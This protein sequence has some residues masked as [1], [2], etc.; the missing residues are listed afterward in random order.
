MSRCEA[1]TPEQQSG[2]A[3]F[4]ALVRA[5]GGQDA[6]AVETGVRRQKISDMT[7][8]N[9][10]VYPT[11]DLIDA[12]EARTVGW[13]GWPHVT[14]WLCRQR[15]GLFVPLPVMA[16]DHA[17]LAMGVVEMAGELGDVSRAVSDALCPDGDGGRAVTAAERRRALEELDALDAASARLRL[18]LNAT[19]ESKG[20]GR[21]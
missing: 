10:A 12:L 1:L 14:T 15:G 8:P 19:G 20:K 9:V 5:F 2:K 6:V 4:K 11:L 21:A 7:L 13:P 18:A 3:A 16:D 17:G